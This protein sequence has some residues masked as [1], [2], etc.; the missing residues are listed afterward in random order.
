MRDRESIALGGGMGTSAPPATLDLVGSLVQDNAV[1]G[2]Y[3]AGGG[4]INA[5]GATAV[6]SGTSFVGDTA[7]GLILGAASAVAWPTTPHP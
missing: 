6:V 1:V 7:S 3:A 2:T 5:F 4:L